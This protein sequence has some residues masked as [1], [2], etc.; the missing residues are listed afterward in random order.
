[1]TAWPCRTTLRARVEPC[2]QLAGVLGHPAEGNQ[3][4]HRF[5]GLRLRDEG[6]TGKAH[7]RAKTENPFRVIKRQ[8]GFQ[9]TRLRGMLKT[10]CKVKVL[11]APSNRFM[12]RYQL[13]DLSPI[14][15]CNTHQVF[16]LNKGGL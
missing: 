8:F 1:M 15:A 6:E 13:G 10:R 2:A 3:W 14:Q 5:A 7:I 12:V 11:A 9:M 16:N 4:P